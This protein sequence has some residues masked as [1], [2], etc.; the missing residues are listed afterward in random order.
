L[1]FARGLGASHV[2]PVG[3][4]GSSEQAGR[5]D[6]QVLALACVPRLVHVHGAHV[7]APVED[8]QDPA[9]SGGADHDALAITPPANRQ[10]REPESLDPSLGIL[11]DG[12]GDRRCRERLRGRNKHERHRDESAQARG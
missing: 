5:E 4:R 12:Q 3:A 8:L 6:R 9:F 11:G 2:G 7:P 1:K 10:V